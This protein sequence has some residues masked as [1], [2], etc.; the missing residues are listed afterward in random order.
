LR[1]AIIGLNFSATQCYT[2]KMEIFSRLRKK[3]SL[4]EGSP[5]S[6]EVSLKKWQDMEERIK[7]FS[8]TELQTNMAVVH[9]LNDGSEMTIPAGLIIV[10]THEHDTQP[11]APGEKP[12]YWPTQAQV[13]TETAEENIHHVL[14]HKRKLLYHIEPKSQVIYDYTDPQFP[15]GKTVKE[16]AGNTFVTARNIIDSFRTA[17]TVLKD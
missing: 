11:G 8:A 1:V 15:D 14:E 17:S 4:P 10:I 7:N 9:K 3:E 5:D 6:A 13:F 16:T 12:L 2:K